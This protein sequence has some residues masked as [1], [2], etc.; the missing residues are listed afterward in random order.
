MLCVY[1]IKVLKYLYK[2][3]DMK[4]EFFGNLKLGFFVGKYVW[5]VGKY[6]DIFWFFEGCFEEKKNFIGL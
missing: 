5:N 6:I 1:I 4:G 3:L 2:I